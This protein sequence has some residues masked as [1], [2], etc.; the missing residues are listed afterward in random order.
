M[1]NI[2]TPWVDPEGTA[3]SYSPKLHPALASGPAE[4]LL[5]FMSNGDAPTVAA[6][7]RLY[8]PQAVRLTIATADGDGSRHRVKSDDEAPERWALLAA[9]SKTYSNCTPQPVTLVPAACCAL[10]AS[11]AYDGCRPHLYALLALL[12]RVPC[13]G[14]CDVLRL[15]LAMRRPLPVRRRPR[16]PAA[17]D[18]RPPSLPDHLA[19]I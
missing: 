18:G 4:L 1:Y 12:S 10:D 8:V 17:A 15:M 5:T 9:G 14:A 7:T 6:D 13:A 2:S 3:F 19:L 16:L 11:S